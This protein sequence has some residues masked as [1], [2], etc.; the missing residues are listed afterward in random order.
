MSTLNPSIPMS[1]SVLRVGD[2]FPTRE[3]PTLN[4]SSIVVPDPRGAL[5]HLQLR[6][7]AGCP[8]CSLHLRSFARRHDE[9]VAAGV[10]EVS[11]FHSSA[12]ELRKV[13]VD[14]PFDVIPDPERALYAELGVGVSARAVLDPRAWVAAA[15]AV[16]AG[17][18]KDPRAGMA[19]GSFGLPGDFLIAADGGIV[20]LK[21]G[22]HAN[23]QWSVDEV[24]AL[25]RTGAR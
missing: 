1:D 15:R 2:R 13:H 9:L 5:V 20:A 14:L 25:V 4:G 24:L 23:D 17:A 19:D 21:R 22:V 12:A 18:S 6:R 11:V 16:A 3:L 7:Y 8:I 10:R